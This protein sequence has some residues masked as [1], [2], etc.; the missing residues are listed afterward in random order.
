MLKVVALT[1]SCFYPAYLLIRN[2]QKLDIIMIYILVTMA[3][4]GEL[5]NFNLLIT[6][7]KFLILIMLLLVY[8]YCYYVFFKPVNDGSIKSIGFRKIDDK[9]SYL[10]FSEEK[11]PI[12]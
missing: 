8:V 4:I 5:I 7:V 1:A 2:N 11:N 3:F 12:S 9:K 10:T 6:I